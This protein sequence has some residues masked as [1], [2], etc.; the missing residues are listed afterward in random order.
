LLFVGLTGGIGSGKSEAL[1]ACERL[2]AAVLSSDQVVHELLSTEELRDVLA[3]RWGPRVVEDGAVDRAVVAEIVFE[4]P[5][6]LRWLEE[7]LFP[8]VGSRIATWR[9]DLEA[10]EAAE[11]AEGGPEVAVVEVP[12]LFEAGIAEA[13]DATIAV[14]ADED[15]RRRRAEDRSH[16]GL[17]GRTARQLSQEDKAA[18]ADYVLRNDGSLADL[19]R[20]TEEILDAL[21]QR[22]AR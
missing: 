20:R 19:E 7:V 13:F 2:G 15:D 8:R 14:V 10:S 5:Q 11:A 3:A 1:A 9:S 21:R 16:R 18:R 6:E 4:D 22:A 12:L 17:G